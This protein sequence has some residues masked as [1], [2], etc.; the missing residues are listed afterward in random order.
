MSLRFPSPFVGVPDSAERYQTIVSIVADAD[1]ET[2][3]WEYLLERS[4]NQYLDPETEESYSEA[5][6]DRVLRTFETLGVIDKDD[7]SVS[8][9][10]PAESW[11]AGEIPFEEFLWRSIKRS[12][13][14]L[15]DFPIG[16]EGLR[17]VHDAVVSLTEDNDESG[18]SRKQIREYL[19]KE[20]NYRFN[21]NGVRGYPQ[22]LTDLGALR[23]QNN[24]YCPGSLSDR[25]KSRLT[26]TDLFREFEKRLRREGASAEPPDSR[27][28]RD[29]A[30]Y[31]MYRESG[32]LGKERRWYKSFWKDYLDENA[33]NGESPEAELRKSEKYRDVQSERKTLFQEVLEK[34]RSVESVD[35]KGLSADVLRRMRDAES[36]EKAQQIKI[37][38]GSGVSRLDIDHLT[39][40]D[41][42]PYRFPQ[43][44]DLYDWQRDAVEQWFDSG[45]VRSDGQ[46]GIA[47]VV[48]GAGKTVMALA[49]IRQWLD[50]NPD[51]VVTV[52][53]PTKVLMH[54]W[55]TELAS[56]LNVPI[57]DVGWAGGGHKDSFSDGRRILVSIVNSAVKDDYLGEE[58]HAAESPQHLLVADECHRYTG[59]V[60]SNIFKYPRTASLGLS[61]TPLSQTVHRPSTREELAESDE[62]TLT[63]DDE[64]LIRE[65][66]EVYYTLTYDEGLERGLIPRFSINY[67]GFDLAPSERETY[68]ALS[69]QV[70]NA[71]KDIRERHGYRLETM[72]GDF[73]QNLQTLLKREDVQTP[74]I[75][76][77]F[78]YTTERRDLVSNAI[79]RQAITYTLL[80]N[81]L[82]K[83]QKAIVFQERINQ[84]ETLVAPLE[85]RQSERNDLYDRQP[86]LKAADKRLEE[87]FSR[88]E[89]KPVMYHSGHS[90]DVWNDFAME[91]FREGG[92]ANVMLSVKALIE[93]V[94]VPS[95]DI[96]IVRVSSSSVRQR[97]QTLGRVLRTGD[98]LS[99][100]SELFVLYAR[101][102]VDESIFDKHDWGSELANAEINHFVWETHGESVDGKRR[103]ATPEEIP[104][105]Q[106]W[107]GP[108]V[109]DPNDL[110]LGDP[111]P[112]P[113]EGHRVSVDSDGQPF[114]RRKNSRRYITTDEIEIAANHVHDWKG[115]GT[116]IINEAGHMLT[117]LPDDETV[118]L[119]VVEGG[120]DAIE[121]GE[122][123][124]RLSEDAPKDLDDV[125]G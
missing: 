68:D 47:Q 75:A 51:G 34:Y 87:L 122:D 105:R 28:K 48:T 61:A 52:V 100:H 54:Q 89:Y 116:I 95:A 20:R 60:F 7:E 39:D 104:S 12:W 123:T 81:A 121:Y 59:D 58:L 16:I 23:K 78:E 76:D 8:L 103:P 67:V 63:D 71:L 22:L 69:R 26:E 96:G 9:S 125:F 46:R 49:V 3:S 115:G 64:L 101:D 13:I 124:G 27:V 1:Q 110:E 113:K 11:Y 44:F 24:R 55:L 111:Y 108:D 41:R 92:F 33:R 40:D 35:I 2:P 38:A 31:Y 118:F 5:Y 85:R 83:D 19:S 119:G 77:Y 86:G 45:D 36:F 102:T 29:L 98:D 70:S 84:L 94:D 43:S 57:E 90:R 106:Q 14:L 79:R 30:K 109:P 17:E 37:A 18:C 88:A 15:N 74:N 93:G 112:G 50:R 10:P 32:G 120:F 66:G 56:K 6:M 53:V 65:L 82:E 107:G 99:K 80:E 4:L 42:P 73:H 91:W 97:I 72:G 114:Q 117:H 25:Y 21:D 62:I